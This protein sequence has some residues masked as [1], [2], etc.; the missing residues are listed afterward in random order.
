VS[1]EHHTPAMD[2]AANG[3]LRVLG[4]EASRL[5]RDVRGIGRYV[6]AVLPRLLRERPGLRMIL[7]VKRRKHVA[8]LQRILAEIGV[9]GDG[10]EVRHLRELPR[11]EADVVWYPWNIARPP[12]VRG[13]MVPSMHD[14]APLAWPDPRPWKWWKNFRWRRLY[15]RTARR[16]TLIMTISEFS[17]QE[18]HRVL[19]VPHERLRVTLL[20][21]DDVEVPSPARDAGA[22]ARL[23]VRAPYLLTVGAADR[24]KNLGLVERAMRRVIETVPDATLVLAGPR[25]KGKNA[26]VDPPWQRTL[27]FVSDEDL[28]TLYRQAAALV[29][30][31]SYEGFGL[32]VL[33]AMRFGAPVICARASSL[34]EVAGSAAQWVN[35]DDDAELAA[36]I[37]RTLTDDALRARMRAASLVQAE[38]FSWDETAR[39]TLAVFDEAAQLGR[40]AGDGAAVRV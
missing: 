16:S 4:V 40:E 30:P 22:L 20:A 35:P 6:R 14:I 39:L 23:N 24:R 9:V 13:A 36:A 17:A 21:A 25:R 5:V 34:P 10:I 37:R 12:R 7:F 8:T 28:V 11:C 3:A 27:G 33:E 15:T 32:P 26:P 18:I 1:A 2:P 31:T 29:A 19:G 38:H